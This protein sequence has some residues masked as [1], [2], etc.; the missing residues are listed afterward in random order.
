MSFRTTM[1]SFDALLNSV[2]RNDVPGFVPFTVDG[3]TVGWLRPAVVRALKSF[4]CTFEISGHQVALS[5]DLKTPEARTEALERAVRALAEQ[6]IVTGWRDERYAAMGEA[7]AG[8]ALVSRLPL[9]TIERAA[10]RVFGITSHAV[11]VNGI[12]TTADGPA[13]WIARR[14]ASKAVDPGLLDNM[15]GGGVANGLSVQQSL[16]KEA[17]E[18][19]GLTA[20]QVSNA[21]PGRRLRIRREVPEGL[22]SEIIHVHDLLLP[23]GIDPRNQDGEVSEFMRVEP[24]VMI[25]LLQAGDEMTADASLVTLD[26]LD[27]SGIMKLP[28]TPQAHAIFGVV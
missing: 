16:I 28:D 13:L 15:V 9:F 26:W 21:T 10:A 17:W 4:T 5:R 11:H 22:Q 18:E 27:R 12:V 14:S 7:S 8:H 23:P 25:N 6:Q 3:D 1:T 19:A 2:Y 24:A 20:E